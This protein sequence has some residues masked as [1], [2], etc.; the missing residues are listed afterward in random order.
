MNK[1]FLIY[2]FIAFLLGAVWFISMRIVAYSDES[3]HYHAN[4]NIYVNGQ[5]DPLD[6]FTQ[7]EEVQACSGND[8]SNP[9]GRAHLHKPNNDV[10]HVH[11]NAVTWSAFFA[12]IG[13]GI[14]NQALTTTAGTFVTNTDGKQLTFILN[15]KKVDTITNRIIGDKDA[16]LVNYG[17]EDESTLSQRYNDIRKNAEEV[18]KQFDPATCSGTK[19]LSF[20]D[21]VQRA[22]NPAR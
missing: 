11:D 16:L 8:T 17:N 12:N 19:Q 20:W 7:Y 5:K 4:V 18:D 2:L 14:T 21:K 15:G 10:V 13:Y 22:V 1:K 9:K 6:A 3:I